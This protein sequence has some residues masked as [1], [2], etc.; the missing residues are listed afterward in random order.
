M[1]EVQQLRKIAVMLEVSGTVTPLSETRLYKG[2]YGFVTLQCYVPI[3]QNR[4]EDT[5]PLC[6]VF[7]A[8]LDKFGNRKQFNTE[9]YNMLRVDVRR[10][11]S[12]ELVEGVEFDGVKFM[13]FE[14]PLPKAFT[15]IVGE[16]ELVFTYFEVNNENKVASRLSSGIYKTTVYDGVVSDGDIIALSKAEASRLNDLT[17]KLEVME[18]SIAALLQLPD[19]SKANEVGEPSVII[20]NDGKFKFGNLKGEKGYTGEITVGSVKTT[21]YNQP[22]TVTNS[23]TN[24]KAVLDFE[25]PQGKPALIKVGKTETLPPES[26]A[27]VVNVGTENEPILDFGIPVGKGF[28]IEKSY[29]SV[30]A[31]NEGYATDDV[32]LFGFVIIDTGNVED[33][34]NAK[35]YIKTNE[36]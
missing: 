16:L 25:I 13:V 18:D 10:E 4:S 23:G 33:E 6:T 36:G 31:M 34:D 1:K 7:R 12:G 21:H 8:T 20:D 24:N 3:T 2:G 27:S 11:N 35:L 32:S 22:A 28:K 15:D 19:C 9:I 29:S 30:A 17:Y 14:C 5:S 26:N